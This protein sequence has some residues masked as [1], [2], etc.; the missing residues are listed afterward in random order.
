MREVFPGLNF[1]P[2]R[3]QLAHAEQTGTGPP[4]F[5]PRGVQILL[6]ATPLLWAVAAS[7]VAEDA[8]EGIALRLQLDQF[9]PLLASLFLLFL[10]LV[11]FRAIDAAATRGQFQGDVL[12]LPARP[13]RAAE[14][15]TGAA[16]GWGLALAVVLPI[17]LTGHLHG[18][19]HW[20][21]GDALAVFLAAAA[22]LVGTL[23]QEM[24]FRGYP[25]QRLSAAVGENWAAVLLSFLFAASL[26]YSSPP[27]RFGAALLNGTLLGVLL[28]MAY[29]RTHSLALGWGMHFL[30]RLVVGVILG[31]TVAGHANSGSVAQLYTRGPGWLTGGSFGPD[32]AALT[33]L[34][35]LL[36]MAALYRVTREYAWAYT[37][38][39]IVAAG[40]EVTV[41]PPQAH[42]QMEKAAA[43]PPPLV[44]ILPSTPRNG[45]ALAPDVS[46]A[47][48]EGSRADLEARTRDDSAH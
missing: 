13:T 16:I 29:L 34:M 46:P 26:V 37:H 36:A 2:G 9:E 31:L 12:P 41:A 35:L 8:A 10:L 24:I 42:V 18:S 7:S 23:A 45:A 33:G 21:P 20:Q 3:L 19:L 6:C 4:R 25:F 28:A 15:G 32:A 30:Y 17:L 40:Y 5:I 47:P 27:E 39:P 11:G 44:Q 1:S 14:W 48:V 38:R 22:L 43:A